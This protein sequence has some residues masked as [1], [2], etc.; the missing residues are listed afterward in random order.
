MGAR[1]ASG[2][3][4]AG[5]RREV[6]RATL[7]CDSAAK[8]AFVTPMFGVSVTIIPAGEPSGACSGG[9]RR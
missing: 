3:Q 4:A 2:G 9:E 5:E 7:L 6:W 1:R 8:K